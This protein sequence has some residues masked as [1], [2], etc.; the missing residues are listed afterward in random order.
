MIREFPE[1]IKCIRYGIDSATKEFP[2]NVMR[3]ITKGIKD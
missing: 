1:G 3:K 2:L